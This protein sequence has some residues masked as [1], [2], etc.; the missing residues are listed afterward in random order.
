[1]LAHSTSISKF[2][3]ADDREAIELVAIYNLAELL[4]LEEVR[5]VVE[6]IVVVETLELVA[7]YNLAEIF[8]LQEVRQVV[9]DIVR[10][11]NTCQAH[12]EV[13]SHKLP[14]PFH[15]LKALQ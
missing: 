10:V 7:I 12:M 15:T 14:F 8:E 2:Q 6:E 5:Q 3:D 4:E 11:E 9:A 13:G 1:M